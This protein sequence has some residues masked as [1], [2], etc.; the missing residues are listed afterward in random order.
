V[1]LFHNKEH[2]A[3]GIE[4]RA[5]SAKEAL[6]D[7]NPGIHLLGEDWPDEGWDYP[8]AM[9]P[10]GNASLVR[11][12]VAGLSPHVAPDATPDNIA[13]ANFDYAGLDQPEQNVRI[14]LNATVVNAV[15]TDTGVAMTY[16]EEGQLK[17]VS[18]RHGVLACYHSVIPHLC[19]S[20]SDRQKEALQYQ[21]KIPLIL[22][23]VLIRDTKALD[24]LGIDAVSF[25]GRLHGR[26]FL[27]RGINTGG[28]QHAMN[29]DGAVSLVF[30]GSVS[31][32]DDAI[33]LKSQLRGSRQ[34]L[35]ELTFE[36]FERAVRTVLDGLWGP[37][38]FDVNEDIL[39]ITVNRWPHGYSYEYMDLWDPDWREGEAP[40]EIARQ[41]FGALAIA[42][43]DAGAS[44]YTHVAI[45]QAYRAINELP[46]SLTD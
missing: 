15:N 13:L 36:D 8:A 16:I 43:S 46:D 39:A 11:L 17:K 4:T 24:K 34:K 6:S 18:A 40:H 14:R 23:N 20:L 27:F 12:M 1:Q 7:G 41:P 38:G 29:N 37:A 5:F 25:P 31:P 26:V 28:Y 9:W 2:G 22:T 42:N 44:A 10:D 21:V 35:L 3:W 19:P 45:D 33:D 32:P 30:W